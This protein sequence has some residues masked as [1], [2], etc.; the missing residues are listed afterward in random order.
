V[1][2][3]IVAAALFVWEHR[4]RVKAETLARNWESTAQRVQ[5]EQMTGKDNP[6]YQQPKPLNAEIF[7]SELS[8]YG[9]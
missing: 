2:I 1:A 3:L 7:L 6:T 8:G 9:R 5:I 4:K